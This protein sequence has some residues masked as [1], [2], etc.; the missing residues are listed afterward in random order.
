[1]VRLAA[2]EGLARGGAEMVPQLIEAL[3]NKNPKVRAGVAR[4]LGMIGPP[5][6]KPAA[7]ALVRLQKDTDEGVRSAVRDAL[8][9]IIRGKEDDLKNL[10]MLDELLER[11]EKLAGEEKEA[12]KKLREIHEAKLKKLREELEKGGKKPK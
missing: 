11:L 1:S 12:E 10:Q 8:R 4:A 5:A 3:K 9:A 2:E 6:G 7:L